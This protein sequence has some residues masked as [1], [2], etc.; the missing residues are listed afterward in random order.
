MSEIDG[1]SIEKLGRTL[2]LLRSDVDGEVCAAAR[3]AS[4]L[5]GNM[6]LSSYEE[7]FVFLMRFGARRQH[8][9]QQAQQE[10]PQAEPPAEPPK[11]SANQSQEDRDYCALAF[12]IFEH[13]DFA[14]VFNAE[15]KKFIEE[16]TQWSRSFSPKMRSWL[17]RLAYRVGLS[18][19]A[20]REVVVERKKR[21]KPREKKPADVREEERQ[22]HEHFGSI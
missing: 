22:R 12:L 11:T 13:P 1:K 21:R 9:W 6:G 17:D 18:I 2:E 16:K 10:Q 20:R 7:L 8:E 4:R 14:D 5:M 3:A 15:E 19:E